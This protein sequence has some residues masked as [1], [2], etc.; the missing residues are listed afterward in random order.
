MSG[1]AAP[2]GP[3]R[4]WI[5]R[6][7]QSAGNVARD[8][9][10]A[11]REHRINA[12]GRDMD[13]PLSDLGVRQAQALGRWL[14]ASGQRPTIVIASTY[15]RARD[16]ASTALRAGGLDLALHT[17]ERLRE[18]EL[19]LLDGLT[20]YGIEHAHVEQAA[21][22]TLLGKFYHRPP[23]GESWCD[24]ILR[25]RSFLDSLC[26]DHA[27]ER[28]VVICHGVVVLCFRYLLERLSEDEIL[29]IDGLHQVANCSVTT[30]RRVA[31]SRAPAGLDLEAFNVTAPL[32]E[33]GE[34]VTRRPDA[35]KEVR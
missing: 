14:V 17:D 22:M 27:G 6:H 26:L 8:A 29:A 2:R 25:L 33:A 31:G 9:A 35:P 16:T 28:V 34:A 24:V 15:R 32:D 4:L 21:Q 18:R 23:G 12:L 10:E 20:R 3:E 5:V 19:G 7:G 1:P 30:Y 11:L 13:V